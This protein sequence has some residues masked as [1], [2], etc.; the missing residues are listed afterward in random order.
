MAHLFKVLKEFNIV[1]YMTLEILHLY[2]VI[3]AKKI[4][5]KFYTV[6]EHINVAYIN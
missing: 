3:N 2:H 1:K 6:M 4:I 5:Q